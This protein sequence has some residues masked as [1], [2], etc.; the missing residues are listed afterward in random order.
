ME[1][2]HTPV[3]WNSSRSEPERVYD[4]GGILVH[5]N[6]SKYVDELEKQANAAFIVRACNSYY[7][8][9]EALKGLVGLFDEQFARGNDMLWGEYDAAK[10]AIAKAEQPGKE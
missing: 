9:L 5:A 2:K 1:K 4:T 6:G 3:P 10:A 7:E 8:L